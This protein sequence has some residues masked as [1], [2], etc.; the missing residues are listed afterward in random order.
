MTPMQQRTISA[1]P[2]RIPFFAD[3][4]GEG[5]TPMQQRTISAKPKRIP[6]LL[7]RGGKV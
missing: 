6:F 3:A 2:K 1:K 7:M 5:M 4:W